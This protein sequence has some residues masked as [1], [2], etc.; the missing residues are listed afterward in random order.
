MERSALMKED[1]ETVLEKINKIK[2]S[3]K[4]T[5]VRNKEDKRISKGR[6]STAGNNWPVP[7]KILHT[8]VV[9]EQSVIF[10]PVI[11][12]LQYLQYEE[13]GW[14][15][16]LDVYCLPVSELMK[17]GALQTQSQ[18]TTSNFAATHCPTYPKAHALQMAEHTFKINLL[19]GNVCIKY[20]CR[21]YLPQANG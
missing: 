17:L 13:K 5:A 7:L 21:D 2:I 14:N 8:K 15:S 11:C 4:K 12:D 19:A 3:L 18:Q 9:K 10:Q 1:T 20:L 6:E 16:L